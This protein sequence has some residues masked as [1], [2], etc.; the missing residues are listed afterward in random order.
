MRILSIST[1]YGKSPT[2]LV[3]C[4]CGHESQVPTN[5]ESELC[6]NTYCSLIFDMDPLYHVFLNHCFNPPQDT[7]P[8]AMLSASALPIATSDWPEWMNPY[9]PLI[10][11]LTHRYLPFWHHILP[12]KDREK[13]NPNL[14]EFSFGVICMLHLLHDADTLKPP[15]A[16]DMNVPK[17]PKN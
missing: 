15:I 10:R 9:K 1:L 2:A 4:S 16:V 12:E 8:N 7:P 14:Q 5:L 17:D 13:G 3:K 6:H 11:Q